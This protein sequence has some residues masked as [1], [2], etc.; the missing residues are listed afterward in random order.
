M[1]IFEKIL[2][3]NILYYPGC[4]TKFVAKDLKEKYEKILRNLG[5][6]FIELSEI[7]KCC[8]SPALKAGYTEDFKKLAEENLKI[9]KEHSVKKIITNCPACFMI[10]KK[11]YKKLLGDKW[12]IEVEHITQTINSKFKIQNSKLQ[13]KIKNE[14]ITFHDPCHLGRQMGVYEEPREIIKKLGYEISEM[15]FKKSE[16][17]CCGAGGGVKTNEPELAN[18][19]AKERIEQAKKTDAKNLITCCPLCYLHL[20]ENAK[21]IE[22]KEFS[23]L[24]E[25]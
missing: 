19:I 5:I 16:S 9:F 17:F 23:E 20:K 2:G 18:K 11:E 24:F 7:E 6:D 13:P 3:G 1:R 4:L 21:D 10:L 15:E 12:D 25:L 14:K 8:G 22:V